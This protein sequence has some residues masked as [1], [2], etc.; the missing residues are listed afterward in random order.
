MK[1]HIMLCISGFSGVGKDE[2]ASVLKA[3]FGA[4]QTGLVDPAKR[5]MA[6]VYGFSEEQLF[7][8]SKMRNKGD[9]RYPKPHL[10]SSG[11]TLKDGVW[12]S[13]SGLEISMED[14]ELFL[15]P[16]EALQRY[17]ELMN[18]LYGDTWVRKGVD[19][20]L[21]I[22]RESRS[23]SRMQGLG[24]KEV[25]PGESTI[26]MFS[27]FRHKHEIAYVRSLKD[28][29]VVLVRIKSRRVPTPPFNHRSETEQ[30]EIPDS[31]FNHIIEND[32][33]ITDL[34]NQARLMMGQ[35]LGSRSR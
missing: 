15:S 28:A 21:Q 33:T 17:C 24:E 6:D 27:D 4:I 19:V 20:Q 7:G 26:T 13:A 12:T 23:Y 8:P 11:A 16:R 30:A 35:I 3:E 2:F 25:R 32:G 10:V 34:H 22:A 14:P 29:E 9:R 31:A 1:R 5:H 18:L